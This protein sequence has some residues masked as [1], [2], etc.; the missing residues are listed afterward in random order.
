MEIEQQAASS[1]WF[2]VNFGAQRKWALRLVR[3]D[4][5]RCRN[6]GTTKPPGHCV[7]VKTLN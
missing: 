1:K 4:P 7:L 3:Q 6:G 5:D 2:R